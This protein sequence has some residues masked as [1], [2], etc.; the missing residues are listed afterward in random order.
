[1]LE[2][3]ARENLTVVDLKPFWRGLRLRAAAE[4]AEARR[5]FEVLSVR[6]R[7]AVEL[8]LM[9]FSGGNQQKVVL[10]KW[11]RAEPSVLLLDEPTQGVDIRAKALLH[12]LIVGAADRGSA[13][14]VSS[15]DV[16]EL[17]SLC[18]RVLVMR[19]G[20]RSAELTG[21]RLSPDSI[22]RACLDDS[23]EVTP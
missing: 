12:E 7:N 19:H 16:E 11:L 2:L 6:P 21:P 13:V 1:M 4:R 17:A 8:P 14:V 23:Q 5:W 3:S 9:A 10:G 20:R 18:D 22:T 15:T